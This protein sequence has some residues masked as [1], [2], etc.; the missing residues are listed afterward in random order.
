LHVQARLYIRHLRKT[1]R[2]T[3]LVRRTHTTLEPKASPHRSTE[4]IRRTEN[5]IYTRSWRV[6]VRRRRLAHAVLV[7]VHLGLADDIGIR[8][9]EQRIA[10]STG[11][12]ATRDAR[13]GSVVAVVVLDVK[14]FE[15]RGCEGKL[16][17]ETAGEQVDDNLARFSALTD[18]E[19]RGCG[20][21][22]C[23]AGN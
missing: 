19:G 18:G 5:C 13:V 2:A 23:E 8:W 17:L 4:L 15:L 1:I 16:R 12:H 21:R 20:K 14:Q 7:K 3:L 22:A 11:K 6:I 9:W 10:L